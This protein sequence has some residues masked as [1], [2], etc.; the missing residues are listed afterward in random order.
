VYISP[1]NPTTTGVPVPSANS[2][3]CTGS[4][5]GQAQIRT[6]STNGRS[7]D[8]LDITNA[9]GSGAPVGAPVFFWERITYSF[10]ASQ[11]Y[12]NRLALFRN[13]QGGTNEELMAPFD[14]SARFK[15]YKSGED[16]A[17]TAPPALS[18]IRGLQLVLRAMSPHATSADTAVSQSQI[19]TAVFFKNVRAY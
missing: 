14:T 16:T 6:V 7:G 17:R 4:G 12:P 8:V 13:V 18:D 11:I 3:A 15:F 5:G 10:R 2:A 19:Y 9:G 1:A